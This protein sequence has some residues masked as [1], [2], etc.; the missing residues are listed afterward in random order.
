MTS[1]RTRR[2]Q[3]AVESLE[4]RDMLTLAITEINYHPV[5][6]QPALGE[7]ADARASDYEFIELMN[8]GD[9]PLNL[10][11]YQLIKVSDEGVEFTFPAQV[12][13]P[14]ERIVVIDDK[15]AAEFRK[16]YGN[17]VPIVGGWKGG[18][19]NK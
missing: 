7:S 3:F 5:E 14:E 10:S 18:L 8:R 11:G 9:T 19:S 17:D 1:G 2:R 12:I 13:A 16:R 6:P 15:A 4:S